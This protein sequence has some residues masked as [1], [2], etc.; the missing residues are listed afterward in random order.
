M[1][2]RMDAVMAGHS[3]SEDA[4]RRAYVPAIHI[5]ARSK[6]WMP[7]PRPGMTSLIAAAIALLLFL[8]AS[9]VAALTFPTLS[10]RVV[11][12]A[13]ILNAETKAA[14]DRK[15]AEFESKTTG[16]LVVVTL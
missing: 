6:T 5:F 1:G 9:A 14:L 2:C 3:A 11:D 12:D 16:Q 10:G 13:G 4:P 15:L 7:G 8:A